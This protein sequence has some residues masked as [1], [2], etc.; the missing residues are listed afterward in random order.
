MYGTIAR[1]QVKPGMEAKLDEL[2][3]EFAAAAVP[4]FITAYVYQME[5]NP[6][7]HYLVVVFESQAAYQANANSPAQAAR[8]QQ[9]RAVMATDPEWHD[10]KIVSISQPSAG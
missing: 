2:Q 9:L 7:D 4:G 5:A 6:H 1:F 8:Y 3:Q 10:G